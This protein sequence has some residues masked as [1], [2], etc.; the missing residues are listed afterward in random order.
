MKN[1]NDNIEVLENLHLAVVG[2]LD[3]GFLSN[4]CSEDSSLSSSSLE[5]VA[6]SLPWRFLFFFLLATV[7]RNGKIR[8]KKNVKCI[9]DKLNNERLQNNKRK[10]SGIELLTFCWCGI[11]W[12]WFLLRFSYRRLITVFVFFGIRID[13]GTR[14]L[15]FFFLCYYRNQELENIIYKKMGKWY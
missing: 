5:S 14:T 7:I 1:K 12:F 9:S 13:F 3:F 11:L 2:F 15:L 4:F 10:C 8:W 6:S